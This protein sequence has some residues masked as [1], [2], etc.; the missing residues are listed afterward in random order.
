MNKTNLAESGPVSLLRRELQVNDGSDRL[1]GAIDKQ[2]L[3]FLLKSW[4]YQIPT[5]E[6]E[7]K[8]DLLTALFRLNYLIKRCRLLF[9]ITKIM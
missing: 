4:N 7:I 1:Y 9:P 3:I 5:W 2:Y 6:G 8:E